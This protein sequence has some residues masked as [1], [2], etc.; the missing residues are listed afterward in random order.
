MVCCKWIGPCKAHLIPLREGQGNPQTRHY[1]LDH[2][3]NPN[4]KSQNHEETFD[5]IVYTQMQL[6][7]FECHTVYLKPSTPNKH[8]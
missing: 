3:P 2:A 8:N 7:T 6:Q 1:I 5:A 4:T